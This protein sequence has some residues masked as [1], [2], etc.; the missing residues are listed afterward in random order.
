MI[1][2]LR[3]ERML[4]NAFGLARLPDGR[5]CLIKGALPNELVKVKLEDKKGVLQGQA[6]DI[7]EPSPYRIK[8]SLHPGLDYGHIDYDYQ[9]ELKQAVIADAIHRTLKEDLAV[10]KPIASPEIWNYRSTVQPVVAKEGLGYRK[11]NTNEPV[12]LKND[13]VANTAIN[14]IWEKL[15]KINKPKGIREMVFR[16]NDDEVLVSLIASASARNYIDFA[17]KLLSIGVLGVSYAQ[18]DNRGRFRKGS[19]RLAGKRTLLQKYGDFEITVNASSFAQPN[20][21]AS[22]QMFLDIAKIV[23]NAKNMLELYAGSGIISLHLADKFEKILATEINKASIVRGERD[24]ARLGIKNIEYRQANAKT[25]EI[26]SN[27]DLIAIDPPRAGLNA[28]T[29]AKLSNSKASTIL[30]ISCDIVTWAR[31]VADFR[32]NGWVLDYFQAYDFFPHTQHI[33]MLSVLNSRG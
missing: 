29:R 18:Y 1:S 23:P 21:K 25:F 6:S 27:I 19:E 9:L 12:I 30:Y 11:A 10:K 32:K 31:D 5:V 22:G 13:P 16:A 24:V 4:H 3:I 14:K 28:Q 8:P 20:P 17:H 7:I 33:E 26:P 15:A 2:E